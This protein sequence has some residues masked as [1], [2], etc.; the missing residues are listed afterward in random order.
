[1]KRARNADYTKEYNRKEV[2]RLLRRT[3]MSRA[4]LARATGLTRAATSLIADELLQDGIVTELPPRAV[5]GARG[6]LATPLCLVPEC[7]YTL[8]VQLNRCDCVVGL[9]DFS[10]DLLKQKQLELEH[11]D[12]AAMIE[13]LKEMC[14]GV[15]TSRILGIGICAPGPVDAHK[16][17]ILNPP[18]FDRWHG[19]C[20]ASLLSDALQMPAYLENDACA[21]ALHQLE[22]GKSQN[23]LLLLVDSGVG[24]G[25]V[26]R[27]KLL[28]GAGNFSCELGHTSICYDG[29][30]CACGNRGCLEA[31]AAIPHL[32]AGTSYQSWQQ[33]IDHLDTDSEAQALFH[34]EAEYL[35]AGIINLLNLI[36]LDTVY[37]AGDICYGFSKLAPILQQKIHTRALARNAGPAQ[38]LL[39]DYHPDARILAACNIAAFRHLLI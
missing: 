22:V 28:G 24:S 25:I 2:L 8:G 17:Q 33:L 27:G 23:F 39:A 16:G 18:R 20:L 7:Y 12:P 36:Q 29:K 3:P 31:Y 19:V 6:R 35:S 11:A 14:Y 15:D 9:C 37:L 38:I 26:T 32:L 10:G 13:A 30:V 34:Q 4:E 1:M 5:S 21:L